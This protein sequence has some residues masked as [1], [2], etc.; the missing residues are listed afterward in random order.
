MKSLR[1]IKGGVCAPLGF[2]A[3][4]IHCGIRKNKDKKDFALILSDVPCAAAGVF[5]SNLVKGAPVVVA[6]RNLQNGKAQAIICNSGNA[7]T[8]NKDGIEVAEKMCGLA[9]DIAGIPADDVIVASTG[10]IGVP[11]DI[12]PMEGA[13]GD[14]YASLGDN[15]DAAAEAI[16]TT[17]TVPKSVAV[18]F[19]VGGKVC[20]MGA[21][22][23][24]VGMICPNMATTLIF[25]TADVKISSAML[26]KALSEDV[27][28]SFN[29]V[30]IDGDQST[31]DTCCILAN[32]LAGNEKITQPCP[33]YAAFRAAL[34]HCTVKLSKMI[35]RDGEGAT[36]LI[37]CNVRG[38]RS[39]KMARGVAKAVIKSS[40]VKAAMF[41]SDA[42]WGR[43][44]CAIGYSGE[45]VD[46]NK[47]DVE[48]RSVKGTLPVCENGSGVPFDED[49]AKQVL[50]R[51]E[52]EINVDLKMGAYRAS[53]WG[54]DLTYDYVKING[55]YRT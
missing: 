53:A 22:A 41:G 14:L 11:L 29:M 12:A 40:L 51:D 37:E 32:G 35:A 3:G 33:D 26:K 1:E 47:I 9:A 28:K 38:A 6:T 23:K 4:G 17:D 52:V 31:N 34:H 7:N 43:V 36:K 10:V 13:I 48:F 5:T 49:F 55:D 19:D 42:N 50:S 20:R 24:G 46:V 16:M 39:V 2:R 18:E 21:I 25:I 8:C 15:S 45:P 54:C 30:S 44:L 27:K